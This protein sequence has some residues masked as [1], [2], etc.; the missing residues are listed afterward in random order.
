MRIFT[1]VLQ[2][3]GCRAISMVNVGADDHIGPLSLRG[4]LRP[5]QS[6]DKTRTYHNRLCWCLPAAVLSGF[7]QKVPKDATR[8]GVELLAPAPKA[9]LPG[10]PPGAHFRY[11]YT[12]FRC[13]KGGYRNS[14][15]NRNLSSSFRGGIT[16]DKEGKKYYSLVH[17]VTMG[18]IFSCPRSR[19]FRSCGA[20]RKLCGKAAF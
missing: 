13:I 14:S 4:R 6:P 20:R 10:T 12:R 9:T 3:P 1:V 5:W 16:L 7:A 15:L 8:G 18:R 11:C 2:I 17:I 19:K